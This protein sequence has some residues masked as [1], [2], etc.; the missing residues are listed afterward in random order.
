MHAEHE[1]P[2][3]STS[4]SSPFMRWSLQ[5]RATVIVPVG[6]RPP[7]SGGASPVPWIPRGFQHDPPQ[8]ASITGGAPPPLTG[9]NPLKCR[10]PAIGLPCALSWQ[11]DTMKTHPSQVHD[12]M[13]RAVFES[14]D[15]A[16]A[17]FTTFLPSELVERLDLTRLEARPDHLIDP[18][19]QWC[20]TDVLYET[21]LDLPSCTCCSSIRARWIGGYRT[22]SCEVRTWCGPRRWPRTRASSDCRWWCRSC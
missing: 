7:D 10:W 14:P 13:L 4:V 19:L 6:W 9:P 18:R 2:P 20:A 1:G 5:P 22:G 15:V 12:S 3:Q 16:R 17:F 11:R 8:V 21:S